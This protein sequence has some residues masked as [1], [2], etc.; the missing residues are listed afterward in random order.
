[1]GFEESIKSFADRTNAIKNNILTEEATKTSLIMPFFQILGYDVFNPQEFTPEYVADVGIKKGEK[2][3]YAILDNNGEPV[4]LIE[5]K[6]VNDILT[7][8]DSQLF[9]Y[10]GTTKAKFA[11]LT[12]GII[13]RFYTDLDQQNIMDE[14]PFFELNML[15]LKDSHIVELK[16]F[17]KENFSVERIMDTASELKYLG[18][19]R[20]ILKNEFSNPSEDFVRFV[21]NSGVYEGVKTQNVV[22]R[23]T[24]LVKKSLNSYINEL[25]NDRI[26]SALNKDENQT[27]IISEDFEVENIPE[28]ID[29][30][31]QIL[32]TEEELES[33]YIV[34]SI[35]RNSIDVQRV[36]FKDTLSYFAI[37]I[38]GKVT[39]W[40]CRVF[41]KENVK[42]IIIPDNDKQ[43]IKYQISSVDDIYNLADNLINRASQL[44]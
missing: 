10:F 9:R 14:N 40:V 21:L 15:D 35:L 1:M 42:F 29:D 13:Y 31:D 34:K 43:N 41:L 25:V 33:F 16:K 23:Y 8:H 4:L 22:D 12:N 27:K 5:A 32:T 36:Q 3:D 37:L 7:K 28:N 19:I 18:L 26:Q 30:Y 11:I 6:S 24:P 20:N 39:K 38:D 44:I 2:V 17:H